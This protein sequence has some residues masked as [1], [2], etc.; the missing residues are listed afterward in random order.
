MKKAIAVILLV[1]IIFACTSTVIYVKAKEE[2]PVVI[3]VKGTDSLS[4]APK[5]NPQIDI[6]R[7]D[8][9]RVKVPH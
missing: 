1:F 5:I 4:I 9:A 2:A 7:R 3:S 8:S 6:K